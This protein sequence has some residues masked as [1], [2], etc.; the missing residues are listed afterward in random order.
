M[1]ILREFYA[2]KRVLVTGH[3][4]FKGGWLCAWLKR[5]GAEVTGLSLPPEEGRPS[6]FEE[7]RIAEGMTSVIGDIRSLEPVAQVFDRAQPEIVFHL[8]AQALVRRS[9]REPV[10]TFASNVMGTVHVLEAA[11]SCPSVRSI[12]AVT[13]DKCYE[14]REW[15]WGYRETDALGG[16]DPYS[17]SK[18]CA[19]LVASAYR[20]TMF[21]KD[22]RVR[23][24][25]ARG[26]NVIGGGD[27]SEDRIVPDIVAAILA[28]EPI[29]LRN[30]QATRPW[31]HVLELV[32]GYLTLAHRLHQEDGMD[33]ATAWNFGPGMRNEANV[34]TL[35]ERFIAS[36]G[37]NPIEVRHVPSAL[38]EA[39][40]LKLDI[41]Q[42]MARLNWHPALDF[43]ETVRLTAEWYRAHSENPGA[44]SSLLDR[45]LADYMERTGA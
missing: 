35:T 31:Q 27:W 36:W 2:G 24:A 7:A 1:S 28:G 5:C 18:A 45:Q 34:G 16:K 13:T 26:G 23:M 15:V 12:V 41:A 43:D 4:G 6:L 11:R 40:F 32:R 19:E 10:E 25:T 9:Y 8:A 38:P 42:A 3:T 14:N 22:G 37:G 20:Q 44:T 30:P 39:N 29:V 17:A 21:A 33:V